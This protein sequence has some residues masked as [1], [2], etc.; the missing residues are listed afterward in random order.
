ME[1]QKQIV[2]ALDGLR[3]DLAQ[4]HSENVTS[5]GVTEK[6]LDEVIRRVDDLH[7]A[8]PGGDPDGHRRYHESLIE[9]AE[10]RTKFYNDLRSE[11]AKKGL[12]A[13][14]VLIGLALWQY[15]KSK[16]IA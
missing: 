13:L 8:F 7:K 15:L 6:K 1:G 11:L 5:L 4:R 10:A 14:L 12:W 16:V 3:E 9:R 2:E